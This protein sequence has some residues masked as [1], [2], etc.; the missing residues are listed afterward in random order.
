MDRPVPVDFLNIED[1]ILNF[2]YHHPKEKHSTHSLLER[3][4]SILRAEPS[5]LDECNRR[6]GIFGATQITAEEYESLRKPELSAVQRAVETLIKDGWANGK[7]DSDA[8]GAVFFSGLAL[9]NSG[10]R[11]TIRRARDKEKSA[12]PPQ[13]VESTIREIHNKRADEKGKRN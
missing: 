11:E 7:R 13:S 4:G 10:T 3:L 8:Q 5:Q 1:W 6:N 9:T 12:N 2:I